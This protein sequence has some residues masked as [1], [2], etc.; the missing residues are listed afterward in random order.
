MRIGF[1]TDEISPDVREAVEIGVSWGINDFELRMVGDRR[2]PDIDE[3]AKQLLVDLKQQFGIHYTAISPGTF[4]CPIV[5][6]AQVEKELQHTLPAT[7][8]LAKKLGSKLVI[9]FGFIRHAEAQPEDRERVL[10]AFRQTAEMAQ[11]Y[12]LT[13]CVEN[14]PGFWCDSGAN[15]AAIL[16]EINHPNLRANW[17]PANGVGT[18]EAP[19][20]DGY[21]YIKPWMANL[22][23][24]DTEKGA[25]V[26]C[27]R[28]G[29]GLVDWPGQLK[30]VQ[31]EGL[32]EW[33]TIET[34]CLPLVDAS[35]Q[36]L[37]T[38]R[39]LLGS[40]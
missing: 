39:T 23:I 16:A 13:V 14:E 35:K 29:D 9:V 5:D 34:H 24:K 19:F 18:G 38:V 28:V 11:E 31:Q 37:Q 8:E 15:T 27:V 20:P 7:F 4:K 1:V 25:L 32:L 22:H 17:D 33:V 10:A 12:D 6:R 21:R 36:N 3:G 40:D 26:E 2:V 30:A